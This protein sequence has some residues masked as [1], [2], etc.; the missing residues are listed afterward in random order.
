MNKVSFAV[1]PHT[2]HYSL[3]I[4]SGVLILVFIISLGIGAIPISVGEIIG[5]FLSKL[6]LSTS[7][8]NTTQQIVLFDIRLPRLV[9]T[10][11]VGA[12]LGV[13]GAALQ[14]LFRNPLVESGLIGISGGASL[15]AVL[16]IIF[17]HNINPKLSDMFGGILLPSSAFIGALAATFTVYFLAKSLGNTNIT[18]LILAGVAIMALCQA[19]I[20]LSIFYADDQQ[21]RTYNFWTL[22]DLGGAN[23]GKLSIVFPLIVIPVITMLT[24]SKQLNA[25]AIGESEAFH[26]GVNVE[27]IKYLLIILCAL[28]VGAAVSLAGMIGFVGL[29]IPHLIRLVFGPNHNI[30]LP[31][32]VLGGAILLIIADIFARTI[33]APA[34]LPIGIVTAL[35]GTPFFIYLLVSAKKKKMI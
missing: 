33:V 6:G 31:G 29:V 7:T 1:I 5:A 28:A 24:Y 11:L 20:G 13:S 35:I 8:L 2:K 23:W 30:V 19:L 32:S 27:R 25:I 12:A 22:G 15:G 26:M 16:I 18:L 34:E 3:S 14:G 21:I 4:L 9:Q 10:V 17:G